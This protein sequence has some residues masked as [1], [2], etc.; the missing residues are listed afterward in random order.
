MD[1]FTLFEKI[2]WYFLFGLLTLLVVLFVAIYF[3]IVPN[4]HEC[5]LY[6]VGNDDAVCDGVLV[7]MKNYGSHYSFICNDGRELRELTNFRVEN[8]TSE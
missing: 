6:F 4:R 3:A 8:C 1:K 5:T 7:E 2:D